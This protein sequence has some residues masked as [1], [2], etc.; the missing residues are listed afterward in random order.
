MNEAMQ[1]TFR[2]WFA[3][4]AD[5]E[6]PGAYRD[7]YVVES[8]SELTDMQRRELKRLLEDT[9]IGEAIW[10][11]DCRVQMHLFGTVTA[12]QSV[13]GSSASLLL[14]R[15]HPLPVPGA[16]DSH[17]AQRSILLAPPRVP[18]FRFLIGEPSE[19][20]GH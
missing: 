20:H 6:Y 10:V 2:H 1:P 15:S 9:F 12:R 5:P 16:T 17:L 4:D 11:T 18:L 3:I 7:W 13:I 14:S 19:W 8:E